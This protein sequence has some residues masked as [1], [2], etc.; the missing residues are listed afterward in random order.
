[1]SPNS[2]FADIEAIRRDQIEAGEVEDSI[3]E[4]GELENPSD[5]ESCIV[6][7]LE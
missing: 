1:M 4:S 7:A 2:K 5:D 6:V 3:N